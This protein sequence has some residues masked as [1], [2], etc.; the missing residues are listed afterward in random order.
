M[1]IQKKMFT[2]K[3]ELSPQAFIETLIDTGKN[4]TWHNKSNSFIFTD[5]QML[6]NQKQDLCTLRFGC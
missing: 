3:I 4:Y 5:G 6:T 2:V 1:L